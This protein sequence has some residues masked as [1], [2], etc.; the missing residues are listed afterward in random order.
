MP[1]SESW[2]SVLEVGSFG[3]VGRLPSSVESEIVSD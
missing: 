1:R 3:P 2:I